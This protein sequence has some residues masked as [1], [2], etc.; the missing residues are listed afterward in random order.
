M[1]PAQILKK[2]PIL[3]VVTLASIINM[4]CM[5]PILSFHYNNY[6]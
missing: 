1:N 3:C 2:T 5:M 6:F 4:F